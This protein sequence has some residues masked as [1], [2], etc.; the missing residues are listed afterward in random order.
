[1]KI[2]DLKC[3]SIEQFPTIRIDTDEGISGFS[4]I[5]YFKNEYIVPNVLIYK[6]CI[7][8]MDPRDVERVMLRIRHLGGFKPWGAAISAIEM[9]LWDLAGKAQ[10]V[11]VHR[12]L[13]GKIRDKVR[14]YLTVG[15]SPFNEIQPLRKGNT[16]EDYAREAQQKKDLPEKFSIIKQSWNSPDMIEAGYMYGENETTGLRM[17][18]FPGYGQEFPEEFRGQIGDANSGGGRG[19]LNQQLTEK[20]LNHIV[21]CVKAMK[22]VL[23]DDVGLALHATYGNSPQGLL[24]IAKALEPYNVMWLEDVLTGDYFPYTSVEEYRLVSD[25]TSTP[26]HTGEQIYLRQGCR[27]LI[28]KHAVDVLGIDPC[29]VGGIAETKWIAEYADLH[30]VTMAPHGVG[31]GIFGMAAMV[32]MAAAMP[33]NYIAFELPYV[34]SVWRDLVKLNGY[35]MNYVKDSYIEVPDTPGVG[36]ELV[37]EAVRKHLPEKVGEE[38]FATKGR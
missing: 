8:G 5:E 3:V 13:G 36:V 12:L 32:H 37:E 31:N 28:E 22:E 19:Y 27:D 38:Y 35:P 1:M 30:G 10:G 17:P 15:A 2:V 4:Q 23:G 29:D 7:L 16:P 11:P 26:I 14:V 34:S 33:K 9:A 20:G 24:S 6:S 18:P 25:N 21:A